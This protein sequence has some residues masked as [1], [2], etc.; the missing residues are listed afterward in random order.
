MFY[1]V[2]LLFSRSLSQQ[3]EILESNPV[4]YSVYAEYSLCHEFSRKSNYINP[5]D[6]DVFFNHLSP[7]GEGEYFSPLENHIFQYKISFFV[8]WWNFA[9]I[10]LYFDL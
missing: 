3:H 9:L 5:S 10:Q 1:K 7:K 6:P 4:S 8:I 2:P